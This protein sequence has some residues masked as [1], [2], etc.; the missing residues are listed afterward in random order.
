MSSLPAE[1]SIA[2]PAR[3]AYAERQPPYAP[4]AEQAVLAAMLLDADAVMRAAEHVDDTM[5]YREGHRRIFRAMIALTERGAWQPLVDS[6]LHKQ[7]E[8]RL[9]DGD[10]VLHQIDLIES[11]AA[12]RCLP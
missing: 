1:F 2:P 8:G 9:A 12:N 6:M 3:D 7:A 5:F 11:P 10:A 4:E